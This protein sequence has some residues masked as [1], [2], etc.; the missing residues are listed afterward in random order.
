MHVFPRLIVIFYYKWE[1]IHKNSWNCE[2]IRKRKHLL[3]LYI[4]KYDH[5]NIISTFRIAD[6]SEV[7]H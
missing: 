2:M 1:Y 3:K 6:A 4:Y 7:I 5:E